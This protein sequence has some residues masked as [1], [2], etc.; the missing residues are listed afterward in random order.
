MSSCSRPRLSKAEDAKRLGADEVVLSRDA[1]EM[2]AHAGSF[3]FILD[4]VSAPHNLDAY[5]GPAQA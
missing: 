3:N 4:T 5:I 1:D 2:K